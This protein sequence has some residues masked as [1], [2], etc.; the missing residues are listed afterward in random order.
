[1]SDGEG[2]EMLSENAYTQKR[3][4]ELREN[5]LSSPP[6]C[7]LPGHLCKVRFLRRHLRRSAMEGLR[8][9]CLWK[10]RAVSRAPFQSMFPADQLECHMS[11]RTLYDLEM[12]F[13]PGSG[14][15]RT[16]K[17]EL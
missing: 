15:V 16:T 8:R 13:M 11:S 17:G 2:S 14:K 7:V 4:E 3:L 5:C 10:E 9:H 6:S 12:E 1:M